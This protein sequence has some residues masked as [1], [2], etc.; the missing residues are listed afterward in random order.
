MGVA[1][2]RPVAGDGRIG[3]DRTGVAASPIS[4]GRLWLVWLS[5]LTPA[6]ALLCST[7]CSLRRKWRDQ[8]LTQTQDR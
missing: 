7:R 3:V 2:W 6:P 5:P 1:G 8:D 4:R